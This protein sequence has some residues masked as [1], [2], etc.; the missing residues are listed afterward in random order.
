MYFVNINR[1]GV[2]QRNKSTSCYFEM[3]AF[4]TETIV[5]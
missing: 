4:I 2:G 5:Q 1:K 3:W